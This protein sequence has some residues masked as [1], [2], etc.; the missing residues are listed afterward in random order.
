MMSE[1]GG[2][3]VTTV[4][5]LVEM[6]AIKKFNKNFNTS[7]M[8]MVG[9]KQS[10][11]KGSLEFNEGLWRQMRRGKIHFYN[12]RGQADIQD[13][14]AVRNYVF[15]HNTMPTDESYLRIKAG[16]ELASN[17][18]TI[19]QNA[20]ISQISE[21][22]GL[23]GADRVTR[24]PIVTGGLRELE[25]NLVKVKSA[26]LPGVGRMEVI[27]DTSMDYMSN[28]IDVRRRG[29]NPNGKDHTTYSGIIWD[30][31]DQLYSNNAMLPEGTVAVGGETK[32]KQNVYLVRPERFPVVW[33]R[34][35]GRYS[36]QKASDILSS[37]KT[38][39][40]SF[41]IYGFGAMWLVDPSKFVMMELRDKYN[42]IK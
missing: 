41:Y 6:L 4:A 20:G 5:D 29:L 21:L 30:V 34:E 10:T 26:Y 16:S 39:H 22:G 25:V 17:I 24:D 3:S 9:G 19:I 28:D 35:N 14:Q 33:G 40:E 37:G 13:L 18:E 8:F 27:R 2:R 12:R 1:R 11:T 36:S 15:K 31:T 42:N 23:L 32:A 38:M 7:L